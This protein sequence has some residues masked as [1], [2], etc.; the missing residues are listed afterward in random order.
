MELWY[1]R[2]SD[3][4]LQNTSKYIFNMR[5]AF[6]ALVLGLAA[7]SATAAQPSDTTVCFT[8]EPPMTCANCVNK[9]KSNLRFE[10]GVKKIDASVKDAVVE[11]TFDKN[12]TSL[13]KL[14][15][16]FKKIGYKATPVALPEKKH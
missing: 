8:V 12:K 16:A 14:V 11:V 1:M 9:I 13:Q 2:V 7:L 5:K 3:T 10:K 15:P 4:I 6:F